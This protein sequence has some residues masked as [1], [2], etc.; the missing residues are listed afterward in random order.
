MTSPDAVMVTLEPT[1]AELIALYSNE[2]YSPIR[3]ATLNELE[4]LQSLRTQLAA[5][6]PALEA[7]A[8]LCM[9][10]VLVIASQAALGEA[11][12]WLRYNTTL[13]NLAGLVVREGG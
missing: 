8:A 5:A 7:G 13:R 1:L 11:D 2:R 9:Q 4:R 6:A 10:R 3:Q 12:E